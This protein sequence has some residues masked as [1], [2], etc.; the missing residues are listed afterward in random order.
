[1]KCKRNCSGGGGSSNINVDKNTKSSRLRGSSTFLSDIINIPKTGNSKEHVDLIQE[2][3]Q[4]EEFYSPCTSSSD[5]CGRAICV[6]FGLAGLLCMEVTSG[7]PFDDDHIITT[8]TISAAS[9]LVVDDSRSKT[10]SNRYSD[11]I[12]EESQCE[13]MYGDCSSDADCCGDL[14]C[15]NFGGF[16]PLRHCTV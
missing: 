11:H 4:C 10:R 13:G 8:P 16:I 6:D 7:F 9:N 3:I 12:Q 1:M 15:K 14:E 5:C 2:E